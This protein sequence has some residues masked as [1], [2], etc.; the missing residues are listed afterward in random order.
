[1]TL[2][3]RYAIRSD[4][5]LLR[6][7]NEDA[8]YAGPRLLAVADGMGGHAAGEVAS[9]AAIDA[10]ARLDDDVPGTDLL[11]ALA[12]AVTDA[13][14]TLH[15]MV[16]ADPAFEGMGTT[17]TA[18]LWSGSRVAVVHIGDSR[19]YLLRDREFHQITHDH[20]L[21]QTLVDEGRI[22]PDDVATHPQRSMLLR[23]LDGRADVEPDLSLREARLG[24][25]YLLCSDGLSSVV[26]EETLHKTLATVASLDEV[27]LQ[28][29]ELAIRGGGPDNI[30]C[31]VADVVDSATAPLPPTDTSVVVGAASNGSGGTHFRTDT[32]AGRAH[33]LTRTAP[34]PAVA[35]AHDDPA[36]PRAEAADSTHHRRRRRLP[37]VKSALV[38]LLILVV[39]GA[40]AGWRYTQSQYYV[41][42]NSGKVV[43]YRGI[44]ESVAGMSLNSVAERTSI[45]VAMLPSMD[46]SDLQATITSPS[47]LAGAHK[48]VN[49]IR[50]DYQR[51]QNAYTAFSKWQATPPKKVKTTVKGKTTTKEVRPT[52]PTIPADCPA[53]PAATGNGGT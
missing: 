9:A 42:A 37:L 40:Y 22:S 25:R 36:P 1:M 2:A 35:I 43:I 30:T 21:V 11:D 5:G 8:A 51:C 46:V 41:A 10:I 49:N 27:V 12:G 45:P 16:A 29:I 48:I 13:N 33:L 38:I 53:P 18:M 19:A 31:I 32:P 20:T 44:N 50:A 52:R 4:V 17:L 24:D 47:G 28:L 34:H 23:A 15:D 6:E 14:H 7:G 39:G 3:L 26:S